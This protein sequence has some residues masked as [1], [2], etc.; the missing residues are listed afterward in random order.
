MNFFIL[1]ACLLSFCSA[2]S[3]V[4]DEVALGLAIQKEI[5]KKK[6]EKTGYFKWV[7]VKN[8]YLT[9]A[10]ALQEIKLKAVSRKQRELLL[11]R[12]FNDLKANQQKKLNSSGDETLNNIEK[13]ALLLEQSQSEHEQ[14]LNK[15]RVSNQ[16]LA[17]LALKQ[18]TLLKKIELVELKLRK[19]ME[20]NAKE[21]NVLLKEY[22]SISEQLRIA[23]QKKAISNDKIEK[24]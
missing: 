15:I 1:L 7:E 17:E 21:I 14:V 2:Q 16:G 19:S 23:D 4:E 22:R 12:D 11:S 8:E 13:Q 18:A 5:T 3:Q 6:L 9:Q 24:R 20:A 10:G